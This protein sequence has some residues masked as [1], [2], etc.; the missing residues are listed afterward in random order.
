MKNK[1]WTLVLWLGLALGG[2]QAAQAQMERIID[3]FNSQPATRAESIDKPIRPRRGT[4]NPD[5]E[6]IGGVRLIE[7]GAAPNLGGPVRKSV[8]DIPTEGPL[9]VES[10]VNS[11][12]GL[13]LTYGTDGRGGANPLNF[14]F[15]GQGWDR[16]RIE[17]LACDLQLNYLVQVF[18]GNGNNSL[19]S[20]TTSTANRNLPFNADFPMA[21]FSPGAPNPVNWHDIDVIS[22][23][24]NTGNATGGQD[25]A[26]KRIVAIPTPTP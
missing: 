11:T 17:F 26:V 13:T 5:T 8:L 24:L 2:S 15:Q 22:I 16:F 6:I 1:V 14:D 3:N 21:N 20:G 4:G 23:Q 10:G 7:F 18:D 19:L 25:F 9:F 12:V